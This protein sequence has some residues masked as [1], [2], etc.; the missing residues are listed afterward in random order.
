MKKTFEVAYDGRQ[1]VVENKWFE[2]EKLYVDGQLQDENLGLSLGA[3][4]NGKLKGTDGIKRIKVAIGG[5]FKIQ[6]KVFVDHE[7]VYSSNS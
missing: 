3:E 7:S 5:F 1:I 6:C 4:L 2:G